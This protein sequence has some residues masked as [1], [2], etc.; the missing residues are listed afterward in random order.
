M[1]VW[2]TRFVILLGSALAVLSYLVLAFL[3]LFRPDAETRGGEVAG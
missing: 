3:E 2:P 1:P